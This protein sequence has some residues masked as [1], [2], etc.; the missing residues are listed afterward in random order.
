ML[1]FSDNP[2]GHWESLSLAAYNEHL[3]HSLRSAWDC[4]PSAEEGLVVERLGHELA[5]GR[6]QF[7][8]VH[9]TSNWAWKDPR[10]CVLL[11]FWRAALPG[12]RAAII[13][14]VRNP[15]EVSVSLAR[16]DGLERGHALA[17]WERYLRLAL[18]A[19][20]GLPLLVL[21]YA[22]VVE[23]SARGL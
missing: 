5:S 1:G 7:L 13:L 16:R 4:P 23:D 18:R 9:P 14:I 2:G 6:D 22:D 11:P 3:L 19:C 20:A 21:E 8:A 10:L 12:T 17:M 15:I